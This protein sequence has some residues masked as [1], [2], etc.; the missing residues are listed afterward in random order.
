MWKLWVHNNIKNKDYRKIKL[1]LDMTRAGTP[2]A[3]IAET[4]A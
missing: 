3:A 2:E 4:V 1:P